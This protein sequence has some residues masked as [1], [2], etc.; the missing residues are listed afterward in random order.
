MQNG[1]RASQDRSVGRLHH[2]G[3]SKLGTLR[4][5]DGGAK[6]IA[7]QR[8]EA[9]GVPGAVFGQDEADGGVTQTTGAVVEKPLWLPHE[10]LPFSMQRHTI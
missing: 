8:S 5:G 3:F 10:Y 7:I 1:T 6:E 4:L 9:K 2:Q